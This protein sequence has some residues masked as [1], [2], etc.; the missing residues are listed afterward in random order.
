M[1]LARMV[2]DPLLLNTR[3][4]TLSGTRCQSGNARMNPNILI[5]MASIGGGHITTA[6]AVE[7]C[8]RKESPESRI[9][10][11]DYFSY[12]NYFER[13]I[14]EFPYL[15]SIKRFPLFYRSLYKYLQS[16]KFSKRMGGYLKVMG[17]ENIHEDFTLHDPDIVVNTVP[18]SVSSSS[19]MKRLY[20]H[21]FFNAV[22]ITDFQAHPMW[23]ADGVNLFVVAHD[24]VR[25]RLIS[26]GIPREKVHVLG[27]PIS[28]RV[29]Q[30]PE[31]SVLRRDLGLDPDLFTVLL[32]VGAMGLYRGYKGLLE[33][34]GK[35]KQP[36][37]LVLIN[38][39][40]DFDLEDR[41]PNAK[42]IRL[43]YTPKFPAYLKASDII[44]GKA[45]GLTLAEAAAVGTPA[46]IFEPIP[47]QEEEN[48]HFFER[49]RACLWARDKQQLQAYLHKLFTD[50]NLVSTMSES[51][52]RLGKP[53]S[54]EQTS[55]LILDQW[56][57]W[58]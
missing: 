55:Q 17:V 53:H 1:T 2:C 9:L 58:H 29:A 42:I 10:I 4:L 47:G 6:E 45:G 18:L 8:F 51:M 24:E 21:A 44:L 20:D 26:W 34:L 5:L 46:L 37:Q 50:R 56:T 30:L 11:R 41:N 28:P 35:I 16:R 32:S 3:K 36:Y 15:L 57:K 14:I 49:H 12:L 39:K 31:K 48:A 38:C 52:L 27:I 33:A 23:I 43:D 22:T 13:G 54:A 19:V 40:G 7:H 25:K